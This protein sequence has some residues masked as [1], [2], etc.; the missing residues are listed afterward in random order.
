MADGLRNTVGPWVVGDEFFDRKAEI[1][2]FTQLLDENNNILL[3]APRRIGKTSL[4]RETFRRMRER[5][6]D[7]AVFV[8]VQDCK[9]PED[10]IVAIA[11]AAQPYGKLAA[12]VTDALSAFWTELSERVESVGNS[13]VFELRLRAGIAGDW[14]V[15]GRN[16]VEKLADADR[17]IVIC[18]DELPIMLN[19]L[20]TGPGDPKERRST[21]ELFFSPGCARPSPRTR[22]GS[23]GSSAARSGSNLFCRDTT[24]AAPQAT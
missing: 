9:S 12:K 20:V 4:V 5:D 14:Q 13:A 8:D 2:R 10:V 24:S 18:L 22:T 11:V 17:P 21:A 7:Y 3:V 1:E 16:V 23:G 19:R 15:K 6:E